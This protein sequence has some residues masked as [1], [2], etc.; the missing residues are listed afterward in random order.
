MII[1]HIPGTVLYNIAVLKNWKNNSH[2]PEPG[3]NFN[4]KL[5]FYFFM[6]FL[7]FL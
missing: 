4:R 6:A 5:M 2:K 7:E 1:N 3:K